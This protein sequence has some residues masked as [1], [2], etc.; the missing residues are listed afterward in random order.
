MDFELENELK[1]HIPRGER[2][3]WSGNSHA[4]GLGLGQGSRAPAMFEMVEDARKAYDIL[5]RQKREN[6]PVENIGGS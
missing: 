2:I 6:Q 1:P 5:M 3:L 4:N